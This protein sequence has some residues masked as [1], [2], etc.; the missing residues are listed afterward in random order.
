M[1][2][3]Y[4]Q[5]ESE[6][7]CQQKKEAE[8]KKDMMEDTKQLDN[9]IRLLAESVETYHKHVENLDAQT[10]LLQHNSVKDE[11]LAYVHQTQTQNLWI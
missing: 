3:C 1:K 9:E 6:L 4:E 10:T 2:K 7:K 11:A 5:E 8:M